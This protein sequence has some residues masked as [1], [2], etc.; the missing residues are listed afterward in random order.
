MQGDALIVGLL[1][2][3]AT[4]ATALALVGVGAVRSQGTAEPPLSIA[5]AGMGGAMSTLT[6]AY[7]SDPGLEQ[8]QQDLAQLALAGRWEVSPPQRAETESGVLYESQITPAVALDAQGGVPTFPVVSAFRRFPTLRLAFVGEVAGPLGDFHDA[9]RYL[10]AEWTRAGSSVTYEFRIKDSSFE[11]E[12]DVRLTDRPADQPLPGVATGS[13]GAPRAAALWVLLVVGSM[14]TGVFVWGL[15]WWVLS[16]RGDAGAAPKEVQGA[17]EA[18]IPSPDGPTLQEATCSVGSVPGPA[19][20]AT[21][22]DA[23]STDG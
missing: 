5:I 15:T 9:N 3:L 13:G 14:G 18:N 2:R 16:R 10:E 8:A 17:G 23:T 6:I 21:S 1:R 12:T 22:G 19:V 11:T 20:P 4:G 7:P